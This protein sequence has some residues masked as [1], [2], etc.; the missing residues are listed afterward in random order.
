MEQRE[1]RY[2]PVIVRFDTE[3]RLRPILI[4]FDESHKYPVDKVLDVR[5]AACQSVGGVGDR[6]SVP[7][8]E[9]DEKMRRC[10]CWRRLCFTLALPFHICFLPLTPDDIPYRSGSILYSV[11][12]VKGKYREALKNKKIGSRTTGYDSPTLLFREN[13]YFKSATGRSAAQND[14]PEYWPQWNTLR[15]RQYTPRRIPGSAA[16]GSSWHSIPNR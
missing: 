8:D 15:R 13:A 6:S 9:L 14:R 3:G 1:K 7:S 10:R 11:S 12:I 4:E 2:V 5:R 16:G